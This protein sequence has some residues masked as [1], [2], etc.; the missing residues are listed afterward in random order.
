MDGQPAKFTL[1][2]G[3]VKFFYDK[4]RFLQNRYNSLHA[5][6][7]ARSFSV[8]DYSSAWSGVPEHLYMDY[9]ET[10]EDRGLIVE[11]ILS[12]GFTLRYEW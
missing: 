7:I 11:R 4:L 9:E 5:E 2:K 1:G 6:C 12:K 10:E 8:Q 3:H